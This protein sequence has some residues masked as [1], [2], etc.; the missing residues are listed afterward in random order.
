M[1]LEQ[2]YSPTF[3]GR[4]DWANLCGA[5]SLVVPKIII[6]KRHF[7]ES[8][9]SESK[10]A[11]RAE[12]IAVGG[13]PDAWIETRVPSGDDEEHQ[14]AD[15]GAH[16]RDHTRRQFTRGEASS[17]GETDR[18]CRVIEARKIQ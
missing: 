2:F 6:S 14:G 11:W 13:K 15:D 3:S 10:L 16:L 18:Y 7:G 1:C 12:T 5:R 17:D 4:H 9:S 8:T